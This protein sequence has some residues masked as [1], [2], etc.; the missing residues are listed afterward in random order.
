MEIKIH[1][2]EMFWLVFAALNTAIVR[3]ASKSS[4]SWIRYMG[5]GDQSRKEFSETLLY[6]DVSS[7]TF[8]HGID[9]VILKSRRP[10]SGMWRTE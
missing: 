7:S 3:K 6:E 8:L 10:Y 1:A 2:S 9:P 5:L 4:L